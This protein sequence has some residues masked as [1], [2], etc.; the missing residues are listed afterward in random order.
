MKHIASIIFLV[1]LT[2]CG[3]SMETKIEEMVA[4][5]NKW[6]EISASKDYSYTMHIK[7]HHVNA[8]QQIDV[9]AGKAINKPSTELATIKSLFEYAFE[10]IKNTKNEIEI[11]YNSTYGYPSKIEITIPGVISGQSTIIVQDLVL[12]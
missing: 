6:I 2:S 3:K 1:F 4:A 5:K 7:G 9:I 12:K 10:T 8:T 11:T